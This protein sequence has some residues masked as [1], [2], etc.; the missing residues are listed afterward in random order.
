MEEETN[1]DKEYVKGY[2]NGYIVGQYKPELSQMLKNLSPNN[3][4]FASGVVAG[5]TQHERETNKEQ[6]RIDM[7]NQIRDSSADQDRD[8]DVT[9]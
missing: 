3:D 9:R 2:N 6:N 4:L 7:L 5:I 1:V 8:I